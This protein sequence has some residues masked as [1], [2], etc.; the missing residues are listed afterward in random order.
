MVHSALRR[1]AVLLCLVP[2]LLLTACGGET[3]SSEPMATAAVETSPAPTPTASAETDS[4]VAGASD[5]EQSLLL[6]NGR[7]G[8]PATVCIPSDGQDWPLVVFCHGFTGNRE[9]DGHFG[10]LARQLA[11][12]GI[13]SIRIDFAGCGD[14]TEDQTGYTMQNMIADVDCSIQYMASTFG[15]DTSEIA[16][17][18]HSMGGRLAS[19]YLKEGEYPVQA[20]A[21]WSPANGDGLT[22]LE[23]LDIDAPWQID[24]MA[25]DA[26]ANGS[27][28]SDV[29][30]FTVSSTLFDEMS[31]TH[32]NEIL[33][34]FEGPLLL[35]YS[36]NESI[37]SEETRQQTIAAVQQHP[38]NWI[39]LRV[40]ETANH[41]YLAA[42]GNA[43]ES[44]RLDNKLRRVTLAFL[45]ESLQEVPVSTAETA[46]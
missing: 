33:A 28:Y 16:L 26:A 35:C 23:F 25:A 18:G 15:I 29:F 39:K 12:V 21:L 36:G 7:S 8:L 3:L 9:G 1:A 17:A 13:A 14:S 38:D 19:L 32:P 44:N 20:A 41:N 40:F 37:L 24:Q 4:A 5:G 11:D 27:V 46:G 2:A 10:P 42:D 31:T 45:Q 34:E 43:A 22:G 30:H 6:D